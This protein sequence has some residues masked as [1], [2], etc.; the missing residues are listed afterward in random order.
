MRQRLQP[1]Y[2]SVLAVLPELAIGASL[3]RAARHRFAPA[4]RDRGGGAVQWVIIVAI[5]VAIAVTVGTII[6]TKI[7]DKANSI[8]VDTPA[9]GS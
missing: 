5:G 2:L 8:N 9:A 7:K 4:D 3:F 6:Y 1:I